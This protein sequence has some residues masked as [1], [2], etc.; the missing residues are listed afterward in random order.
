[1]HP[2]QHQQH[3]HRTPVAVRSS[4]FFWQC[5][6][7]SSWFASLLLRAAQRRTARRLRVLYPKALF[8]SQFLDG[9]LAQRLDGTPT[10]VLLCPIQHERLHSLKTSLQLMEHRDGFVNVL[11]LSLVW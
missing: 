3:N 4:R 1:M 2:R 6:V 11:R 8:S 10:T 9:F 7:C 5:L